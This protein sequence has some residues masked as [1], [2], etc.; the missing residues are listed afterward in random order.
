[1]IWMIHT[2]TSWHSC[3]GMECWQEFSSNGAFLYVFPPVCSC[4]SNSDFYY[5]VCCT[6][7]ELGNWRNSWRYREAAQA[8]TLMILLI[9]ATWTSA[10]GSILLFSKLLS[11]PTPF[12]ACVSLYIIFSKLCRQLS[13]YIGDHLPEIQE[14]TQPRNKKTLEVL[15]REH[16]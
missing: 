4:V 3:L 11:E 16:M 7:Q 5:S 9:S 8:W 1:M 6:A 14:T 13:F 10:A 15:F 12:S 2:K